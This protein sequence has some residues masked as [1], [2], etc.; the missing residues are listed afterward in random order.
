MHYEPQREPPAR[1]PR[2]CPFCLIALVAP[3]LVVQGKAGSWSSRA[4]AKP[5]LDAN[6][7][8]ER[9]SQASPRR[10]KRRSPTWLPAA[11]DPPTGPVGRYEISS[12]LLSFF[13]HAFFFLGLPNPIGHCQRRELKHSSNEIALCVCCGVFGSLRGSFLFLCPSGGR[14]ADSRAFS[15][16]EVAP[17]TQALP[18]P[19]E[20]CLTQVQRACSL[21]SQAPFDVSHSP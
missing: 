12:S 6:G 10:L 18:V 4:G 20:T 13:S 7:C 17:I 5:A 9:G 14:N 1:A 15:C 3:K 8:T 11:R 19:F 2:S 16:Y 21:S